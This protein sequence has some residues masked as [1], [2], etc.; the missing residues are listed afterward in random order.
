MQELLVGLL[1]LGAAVYVGWHFGW[2]S[3]AK[4]R[5]PSCPGGSCIG[6][7]MSPSQSAQPRAEKPVGSIQPPSKNLPR[8]ELP[9]SIPG[10]NP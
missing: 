1:I 4:R 3:R 2:A 8:P 7:A 6:C 5:L 9:G 10:P